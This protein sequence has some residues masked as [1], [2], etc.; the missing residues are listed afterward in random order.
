ML[1]SWNVHKAHDDDL[2]LELQDL[3]DW[4]GPSKCLDYRN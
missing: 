4:D 3:I 1:R 2:H